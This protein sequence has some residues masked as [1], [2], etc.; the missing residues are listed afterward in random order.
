MNN[1]KNE[2]LRKTPRPKN[3]IKS[4]DQ[5]SIH[6]RIIIEI[7]SN[8][9]ILDPT[10]ILPYSLFLETTFFSRQ[11]SPIPQERTRVVHQQM[12]MVEDF[13]HD[14]P[15]SDA[16]CHGPCHGCH[17]CGGPLRSRLEAKWWRKPSARVDL[18]FL[19]EAHFK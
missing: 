6:H 5:F 8:W 14:A 9:I 3:R 10:L 7:Y 4:S 2:D 1:S 16:V 19:E 18:T 12:N 17:G 13:S 11:G 15:S